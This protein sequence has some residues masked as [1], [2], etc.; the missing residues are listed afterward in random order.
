MRPERSRR[1]LVAVLVARCLLPA[2]AQ[3]QVGHDPASSPYRT[4]RYSQFIGLTGGWLNGNGGAL[5]VAPHHGASLGLRYDFLSNGTVSLGFAGSVAN[6]ERLVV[7]PTKP[8][9]TAVSGPFQQRTIIGEGIVQ[10]NVTGGKTWNHI[11]PFVS[12]G[13][14][15]LLSS[16]TP[17]DH[18]DFAFKTRFVLTPGLGARIFLRDRLYLR[19]EARNAFWSV[20]YPGSFATSPSSAPSEPPVLATPHKEWLANGWY[21][22]GL[23]YAFSRPF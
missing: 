9:A 23:S 16:D 6:T 10:F 14:G 12:A 19:L 22:V 13:F 20:T 7:D 8:I 18:S 11:A 5:G 17:E 2:A 21:T 3:A 4:L 1:L 15:I